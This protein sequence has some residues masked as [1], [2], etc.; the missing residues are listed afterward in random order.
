MK[1]ISIIVTGLL[2]SR[3]AAM[4]GMVNWKETIKQLSVRALATDEILDNSQHVFTIIGRE[5]IE[6]IST[7]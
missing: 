4:E 6:N 7:C 5:Q 3:Q 1:S 2:E